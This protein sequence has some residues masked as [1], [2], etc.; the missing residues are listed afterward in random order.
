MQAE[1]DTGHQEL[2]DSVTHIKINISK[3]AK[4]HSSEEL[5][6]YIRNVRMGDT[7]ELLAPAEICHMV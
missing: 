3:L 2:P 7:E 6:S 5:S 4:K 1:F